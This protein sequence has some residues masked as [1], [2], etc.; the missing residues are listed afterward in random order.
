MILCKFLRGVFTEPT[1]DNPT[2]EPWASG[3]ACCPWSPAG[4][5]TPTELRATARRIVLAK[6]AYN[7][8]EGWRPEDDW[9]PRA[10]A[11]GEPR[12]GLRPDGPAH[13]GAAARDGRR[14]LGGPRPRRARPHR[15]AWTRVGL[16][17]VVLDTATADRRG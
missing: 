6:R 4:T 8:R 14:L 2:G 9:L 17:A 5:S 16:D 7:E 1:D 10:A 11:R 12:D 15:G 13:P 3:R